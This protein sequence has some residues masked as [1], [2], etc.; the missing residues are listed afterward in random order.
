MPR[1]RS[2]AW[3]QLKVGAL[4]L[5][6]LVLASVFIYL[7]GGQGGF[8]WQQYTITTRF[9][10][11]QGL[12]TG[13][14]VRVAGVTVGSVDSMAFS[15][16]EVEVVLKISES[17]QERITTD[18]RAFI[19]SL[20]LLGAAVVDITPMSTGEP[21]PDGGSIQSRRPYGQLADVADGATRGLAEATALLADLR[22]G[23]GTV[24]RLFTDEQLYKEI[25]AFVSSAETIATTITEGKGTLGK[26]INDPAV[27]ADLEQALRNLAT[28]TSRIN[29]GEGT[30]GRLLADDA[31]ATSAGNTMAHLDQVTGRLAKGEGTLGRLSTDDAL[32]RRL[33]T[34][35]T[36]LDTLVERLNEGEGTAGRLLRDRELYENMNGAVGEL[37]ALVGDI[38]KDPKKYLNVRVSIF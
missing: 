11:V 28:M 6:A 25:T 16:S 8:F 12:Q 5:A 2:L 9:P 19:G 4:A 38:R 32:Y 1:T 27:H 7:I 33:D 35:S 15:G 21:I 3:S 10:D 18:S 29:A 17:M 13:A 24:G 23:R 34:L 36:R 30:L 14:A 22:K 26:L 31:I 37:R 20:S